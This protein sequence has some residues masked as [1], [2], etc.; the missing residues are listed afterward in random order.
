MGGPKPQFFIKL[1]C[2]WSLFIGSQLYDMRPFFSGSRY[3]PF[4]QLLPDARSS[5]GLMHTYRFNLRAN[6]PLI[7]QALNETQLQGTNDLFGLIF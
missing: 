2:F 1:Q 4:E 7:G 5:M 3:S 6:A